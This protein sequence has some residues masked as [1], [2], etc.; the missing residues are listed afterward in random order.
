MKFFGLGKDK[1]SKKDSQGKLQTTGESSSKETKASGSSTSME[2]KNAANS[3]AN[4]L[5]NLEKALASSQEA[6]EKSSARADAERKELVQKLQSVEDKLAKCQSENESLKSELARHQAVS[7]VSKDAS[8]FDAELKSRDD[9]ILD[10]SRQ[11]QNLS[12]EKETEMVRI[13]EKMALVMDE[14]DH[15]IKRLNALGPPADVRDGG[16][17]TAISAEASKKVASPTKLP[18]IAKAA[19]E[20][21][22]IEAA[23]LNNAFMRNLQ[24][25]QVTQIIDA[26][27][28]KTYKE[29]IDIIREG[30]DG[31]HMYILQQ[32]SV[33]VTKGSGPDKVD[34]C[35]LS[36]GSLFGEL[37]ILYN[38]RRT[39][40]ITSTEKVVLWSLERTLFQTVVKSAGRNKDQERFETLSAVKDLNALSEEKLRKIAD[41]LEEETFDANQCIIKQGTT[42]D[43]FYIIRSGE[44]R[45]TKDKPAG[46]E[47]EVA[48]YGKGR[49]FGEIALIKEDVR[50]ANVYAVGVVKCYTLDR[51][52]FTNLVGQIAES[53]LTSGDITDPDHGTVEKEEDL[54]PT[55]IINQ[56]IAKVS[57]DQLQVIKPLG[58]G[59]FGMVKLVQVNGVPDRAFALKCIQ[60]AR[61]VQYGQQRHIMDEKNILMQIDSPFLLGLHKTFKDNKFV[62]LLTDAYLGGDLWRLLHTKGPFN[63]TNARFYVGCVVEAFAYLHKRQYVY[64]D[65]KPEN[66][67][68]DSKGYVKVVDLGFAKKVL[69]GHKTWTFCGTPE[70][71]P[72]ER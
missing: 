25:D 14:K 28:K 60:K 11:L 49:Y 56:H 54:R 45:I 22:A 16:L 69:P 59:G 15:Q 40:T 20:R 43:L 51:T 53:S 6:A 66:L 17:R 63:D 26:M 62:Y 21:E 41:C 31:T 12:M 65:L 42:G 36:P 19:E 27:E 8:K 33:K 71:I 58:A 46:G 18:K 55:K 38:C 39:A 5:K 47:E 32:G 3:I 7:S 29:N 48:R 52:A 50:M 37:A 61:V 10:L 2:E 72:P 68:I 44:V 57:L 70:Y 1:Q 67:M 23:L 9:K 24:R 34:V 30:M 35:S 64:R 4:Q 13:N